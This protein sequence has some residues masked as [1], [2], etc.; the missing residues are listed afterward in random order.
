MQMMS[1]Q[2]V[3]LC[4]VCLIVGCSLYASIL[5]LEF[6]F[7]ICDV[8]HYVIGI[9]VHISSSDKVI[10]ENHELDLLFDQM[11][12]SRMNPDVAGYGNDQNILQETTDYYNQ[13]H[14][15]SSGAQDVAE[16]DRGTSDVINGLTVK[17]WDGEYIF[18]E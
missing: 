12:R 14:E 8:I 3:L 10:S 5:L 4:F 13:F 17:Q 9:Y 15:V 6:L 16:E 7:F 2:W 1:M 11:L 18:G